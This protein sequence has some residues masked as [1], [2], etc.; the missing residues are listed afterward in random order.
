MPAT[1]VT[2]RPKDAPADRSAAGLLATPDAGLPGHVYLLHTL[3]RQYRKPLR[4][5]RLKV[6]WAEPEGC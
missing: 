1:M 5:L 4:R 6:L 3:R 2:E